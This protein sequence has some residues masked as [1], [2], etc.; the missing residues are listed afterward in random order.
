VI[1]VWWS[2]LLTVI[3]VGGLYLVTRKLWTG[4]VVGIGVQLL[5]IAYAVVTKQWGF[6][7]SA[8]AYGYVNFLGLR[9]WLRDRARHEPVS[10]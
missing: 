10:S 4:F 2:V 6:I 7:G 8:L 3:G 1:P 5:W 9:R